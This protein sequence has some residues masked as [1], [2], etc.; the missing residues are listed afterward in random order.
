MNSP[1]VTEIV[2]SK[3]RELSSPEYT[4]DSKKNKPRVSTSSEV[5]L[6][7]SDLS[8]LSDSAAPPPPFGMATDG[9]SMP[10][11]PHIIIPPSEMSKLSEMLKDT[12]K[13]EIGN[14]VQSIVNGVLKGLND[15]IDAMETNVKE[16]Q[17]KN[18]TLENHNKALSARVATLEKG[19]DQAEQYSRRN[20]LRITGYNEAENENTDGI[21]MQMA[22]DIG[23]DLHLSEIDRSHRVGKPDAERTRPREIIVKFTSYRAR[24]KLFKM[25]TELKNKGYNGVFLNE[26][27]TRFRSKLLFEARKVVKADR[28]KGAW[29][30]DGNILIKDYDDVVHR[31]TDAND[32]AG[33]DFPPK[34][35]AEPMV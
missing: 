5:D 29:S 34:P 8:N 12:F 23:V 10:G 35:H 26:D 17:K 2:K 7:I 3:K 20:N 28:A 6:D 15:R 27:L 16:L 21:V 24:Q 30:S 13:D 33:I 32:L 25:R 14:L 18:I 11:T 22:S 9:S 31:L 1:I 4:S 19:V